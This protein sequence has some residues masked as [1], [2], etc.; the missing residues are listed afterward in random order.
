[1][2]PGPAWHQVGLL[3]RPAGSVVTQPLGLTRG[4]SGASA[5]GTNGSDGSNEPGPDDGSVTRAAGCAGGQ[6]GPGR[7]TDPGAVRLQAWLRG[8]GRVMGVL[9]AL[10][11]AFFAFQ[12]WGTNLLEGRAQH[13][14]AD[15]LERS[16]QEQRDAAAPGATAVADGD[17]P[18]PAP[19][20]PGSAVARIRLPSLGVD[21]TV[22]EGVGRAEL[23][24]GPGHNP[25]T[26]LPGHR[27][28]VA[29]AGHRTTH[30]A[31][32]ADL[33]RLQP[34]DPIIV[35]TV[36]G[37]FTYTVMAQDRGDGTTGGYR[38]VAPGDVAVIADQGD[39]RLTLTSCYPRY[40]DRQ[41][42]VVTA[43][44]DGPPVDPAP[45][46]LAPLGPAPGPVEVAGATPPLVTTAPELPTVPAT[47]AAPPGA[48]T[49]DGSGQL[50][51]QWHHLDQALAWIVLAALT[52]VLLSLL[53]RRMNRLL[54]LAL[55]PVLLLELV[56]FFV[57]VDRMLPSY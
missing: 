36:D 14:L 53:G 29:I 19:P 32:F 43:L 47:G 2:G 28:N 12:L 10:L 17:G 7:Q 27:G 33:D 4:A 31:P 42:L 8:V 15:E 6:A 16:I 1:M 46:P 30:G 35:D 54:A 52:A 34:G 9:G 5:G 55:S 39:N 38:V 37:R 25:G 50:G 23:R 49:L 57:H 41:R 44:L 20:V 3:D 51:W 21:E 40:S 22:V 48:T 18:T 26:P 13:R 56:I 11:L 24:N 45:A